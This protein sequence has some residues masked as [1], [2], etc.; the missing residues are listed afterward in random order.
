MNRSFYRYWLPLS[1]VLHLVLLALLLCIPKS[2]PP[3]SGEMVQEVT[4]VPVPEEAKPLPRA[5]QPTPMIHERQPRAV[6]S[7][8]EH[9][10][11]KSI[12]VGVAHPRTLHG[13]S[14]AESDGKHAGAALKTTAPPKVMTTRQPT[15]WKAAPGL[16]NGTGTAGT[17]LGA[18]GPSY[19]AAALG[20]P[21]IPA[22]PKLAQERG[23]EGTV[24]VRITISAKG[25]VS[26]PIVV[27]SS[28][29]PYLDDAGV[30]AARQWNFTPAVKNGKPMS[31]TMK[32]RFH[33]A[34]G[35]VTGAVEGH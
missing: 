16:D 3:A 1:V 14:A 27:Q 11:E 24:V 21:L 33:F 7:P 35:A 34:N 23:S 19:G 2:L 13:T 18:S 30:S 6:L 32:L 25:A 5:P 31:S 20:A 4:V 12:P 9:Q 10:P 26:S 29:D 28:G 17:E 15:P 22:Y 8:P